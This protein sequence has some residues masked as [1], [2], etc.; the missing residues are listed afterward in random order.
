MLTHQ[1][2]TSEGTV[3]DTI[4]ITDRTVS[5]F[6]ATGTCH[7]GV[8]FGTSGVL[9]SFQA[10]GGVSA[11]SGEWLVSG[12]ASGFYLQRTIIS[13]TLEADPGTGFKQLN[14]NRD[15]DNQKSSAGTKTTVVFFEISSDVSGSPVVDTATMTFNSEQGIQ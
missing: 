10:N 8:R 2:Q 12:T 4:K 1:I 6:R 11:I 7:S 9:S 5:N 15:Y 13:G 14:T 3:S